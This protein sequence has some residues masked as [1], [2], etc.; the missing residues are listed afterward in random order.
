MDSLDFWF[1][2][3]IYLIFILRF[4]Y[5][6][7]YLVLGIVRLWLGW[8]L[9]FFLLWLRLEVKGKDGWVRLGEGIGAKKVGLVRMGGGVSGICKWGDGVGVSSVGFGEV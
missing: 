7:V 5:F 9:L 3:L 2:I 1:R 6:D 8:V 4:F